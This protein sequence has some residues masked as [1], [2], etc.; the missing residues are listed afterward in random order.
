MAPSWCRIFLVQVGFTVLVFGSIV[1]LYAAQFTPDTIVLESS[2]ASSCYA[3]S[4]THADAS[5]D[6][7]DLCD[8]SLL[9]QQQHVRLRERDTIRSMALRIPKQRCF[10]LLYV[11]ARP[12]FR[13]PTAY[14]YLNAS[15]M[16]AA[17]ARKHGDLMPYENC[18]L[19]NSLDKRFG[20]RSTAHDLVVTIDAS[21]W[22]SNGTRVDAL[23]F[24][25]STSSE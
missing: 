14:I 24:D 12:L 25:T 17:M 22:T 9:L 16:G 1:G 7:Y 3:L 4:M 10:V 23:S 19:A 11:Q 15:T 6:A 13:N 18:T 8:A 21:F 2:P 20:I 5:R